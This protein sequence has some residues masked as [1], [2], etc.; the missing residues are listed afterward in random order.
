MKERQLK[1]KNEYLKLII[2]LGFDYDGF[3]TVEGLKALIDELVRLATK[4]LKND[5]K[6]TVYVGNEEKNIL[7]ETMGVNNGI[8]K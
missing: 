2:A 7:F 1:I 5:D 6:S 4:A 8:Y 3:N